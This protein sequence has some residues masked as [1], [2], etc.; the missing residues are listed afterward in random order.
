MLKVLREISRHEQWGHSTLTSDQRD[1][2]RLKKTLFSP[3][4]QRPKALFSWLPWLF[5]PFAL[6]TKQIWKGP[7]LSG[8]CLCDTNVVQPNRVTEPTGFPSKCGLNM[9]VL[10][11]V[12]LWSPVPTQVNPACSSRW[13]F[14]IQL[15][16]VT[17]RLSV[18]LHLTN[19]HGHKRD[20][21][22]EMA[23]DHILT[24]WRE[25]LPEVHVCLLRESQK[26]RPWVSMQK[27]SSH[28]PMKGLDLWPAKKMALSVILVRSSEII[29]HSFYIY[30]PVLPPAAIQS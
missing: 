16:K 5:I 20:G 29:V 15:F 24:I 19:H 28:R 6:L 27:P 11:N 8:M 2:W 12:Y 3:Y 23:T 17:G 21:M 22:I 4:K 13:I 7:L 1:D 18:Q 25:H 9:L 26:N 30:C 14:S 10:E